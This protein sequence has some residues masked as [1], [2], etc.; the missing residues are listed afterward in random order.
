[1]AFDTIGKHWSRNMALDLIAVG[2]NCPKA[3]I[4]A[5]SMPH[6]APSDGARSRHEL[7]PRLILRDFYSE[8]TFTWL[9]TPASVLKSF[10]A[11]RMTSSF[12]ATEGISVIAVK[13][14]HYSCDTLLICYVEAGF[15]SSNVSEGYRQVSDLTR[16][17]LVS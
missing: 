8:H 15:G 12:S 10:S 5:V 13:S 16:R 4:G 17:A 11:Q 2:L 3:E 14:L 6:L 7:C 9:R 1:M